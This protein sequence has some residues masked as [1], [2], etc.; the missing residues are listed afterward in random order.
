MFFYLLTL[1]I[2]CLLV[3][4]LIKDIKVIYFVLVF[5]GLTLLIIGFM[6]YFA[7]IG[8]ISNELFTIFYLS[9][10]LHDY[11]QN[12]PIGSNLLNQIINSGRS[13]ALYGFFTFSISETLAAG[14][15]SRKLCLG[16]AALPSLLLF[17]AFTPQVYFW[18]AANCPQ[19]VLKN[20]DTGFR[21]LMITV[22]LF[23]AG[24]LIHNFTKVRVK[25]LR[26][27]L[28]SLYVSMCA[29]MLFFTVIGI[30]TPLQVVLLDR[31][32]FLL[33]RI[34][35][36]SSR[37]S[38]RYWKAI[39]GCSICFTILCVISFTRY[40][41]MERLLAKPN[42]SIEK[43]QANSDLGVRVIA[44][45]IKNNLISN[46]VI[47]K[48]LE[49]HLKENGDEQSREMISCLIDGNSS[50][51]DKMNDLNNF[52]KEKKFH[53]E[54][55]PVTDLIRKAKA[56]FESI[57]ERELEI[58][59]EEDGLFVLADGQL[60]T[61][62]L[63]NI[64]KNALEAIKG[65]GDGSVE[66]LVFSNH[67]QVIIEVRDNGIG[68]PRDQLKQI[69]TPFYTSKNS[70]NNWGLGLAYAEKIIKMHKGMIR[71]ESRVN[72]GTSVYL[73]LPLYEAR[74]K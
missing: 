18:L 64:L 46:M 24:L 45:S 15:C 5:L 11:M 61:Q 49:E 17:T 72:E 42:G 2:S 55:L 26:S 37:W 71:I 3:V 59:E 38:D 14:K 54:K 39:I 56:E 57:S 7:K 31:I 22:I 52:F 58:Q 1:A 32:Y 25:W 51:L 65:I 47:L 73:M 9:R 60:L 74:R 12:Y 63:V 10:P 8:G 36:Y 70:K 23:S 6:F 66:V 20:M 34:F 13:L 53:F 21:L 68:I 69:F 30:I 29:L 48:E 44:H 4:F 35:F 62:T 16:L 28:L 27:K 41:K 19:S 50:V 43:R 33:S 40:L 67:Y